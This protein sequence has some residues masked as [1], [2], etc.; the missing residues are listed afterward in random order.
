[1]SIPPNIYYSANNLFTI[2]LPVNYDTELV[3]S[4]GYKQMQTTP[5]YSDFNL[6][7]QIGNAFFDISI[8]K[9]PSGSSIAAFDTELGYFFFPS[10]SS[11]DNTTSSIEFTV[12]LFNPDT[13]SVLPAGT[14]NFPITGGSGAYLNTAA[15]SVAYN[16]DS[17]GIR[18][19]TFN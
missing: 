12:A 8:L 1:M 16:V 6:T 9:I 17:S 10:V 11:P 18:S 2:K 5:I 15:T 7:T 4:L 19:I 3:S 14:Y 13:S